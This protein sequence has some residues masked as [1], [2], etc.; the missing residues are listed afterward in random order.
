[1]ATIVTLQCILGR[2]YMIPEAKA[3]CVVGTN[4]RTLR[5]HSENCFGLSKRFVPV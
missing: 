5:D 1:M 2:R 3:L 4:K